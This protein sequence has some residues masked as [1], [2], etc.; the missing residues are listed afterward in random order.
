MLAL[1]PPPL[2]I[3]VSQCELRSAVS[4]GRRVERESRRLLSIL[5][6]ENQMEM[7]VSIR[8]SVSFASEYYALESA[9]EE[10]IKFATPAGWFCPTYGRSGDASAGWSSPADALSLEVVARRTPP[11]TPI[12]VLYLDCH[13]KLSKCFSVNRIS[14]GQLAPQTRGIEVKVVIQR[15]NFLQDC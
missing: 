10:K 6:E 9:I 11:S 3:A 2:N 4:C 15:L 12:I 8:T 1:S 14:A 5:E 7:F 13:Q